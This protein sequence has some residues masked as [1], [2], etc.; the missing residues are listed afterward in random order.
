MP[1]F[2]KTDL[3]DCAEGSHSFDYEGHGMGCTVCGYEEEPDYSALALAAGW[4]ERDGSWFSPDGGEF[5]ESSA[6]AACRID[7]LI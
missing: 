7:G 2:S 4:A 3:L 1:T 5:V 6:R